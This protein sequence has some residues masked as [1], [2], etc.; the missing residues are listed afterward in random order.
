MTAPNALPN[1][2]ENVRGLSRHRWRLGLS[3]S[4]RDLEHEFQPHTLAIQNTPPSPFTR[5]VLWCLTLLLIIL[6]GWSWF[7]VIPITTSAPAKFETD[8]RTKVVQSL[9]TGTVTNILVQ[10][11][12]RVSKGQSLVELDPVADQA[13]MQSQGK[14]LTLNQSQRT[15]LL[16]EI[17]GYHQA[18]GFKGAS[19]SV[20]TLESRVM[21]ADM[22]RLHD[23]LATDRHK[24][25]AAEASLA[26]GKATLAEYRQRTQLDQQQVKAAAPLVPEGA[27]SGDAFDQLKRQAIEDQG[28]LNAQVKQVS[29]LRE[30][31]KTARTQLATDK[32]QFVDSQY[33]SLETN[34]SKNYQLGSKYITA[35]HQ[36]QMDWLRSP[37][38]GTIQD[39][40]VASLGT[41]VQS[42]ETLAT[43]VPAKGPMVVEADL[44]AKQAGF[45][46][47]GQTV[48]IK[49]TA[50][51]FEQYG[52]IPGRVTWVSPTAETDSSI[53]Q[54]PTGEERQPDTPAKS[55]LVSSGG[56]SES[57]PPPTLFY[58]V[59]IKPSRN[60]LA[61]DGVRHALSPGMTATVDVHT[62]ERR[63]IEFFLDPI[64]KYLNN[65]M[66]VR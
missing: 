51:P 57:S 23:Q 42:G 27:M 36:Y 47:V 11:G 48:N 13:N 45:V 44:P 61:A 22:V 43:I 1:N 52:S 14:S 4:G 7:S 59:H 9:N 25:Q 34:Q 65:G 20:K 41:V 17:Q 35:K 58:Q 66:E 49:V 21:R 30:A 31:V 54:T 56:D 62:G 10:D 15:R 39:L 64:V 55:G 37:V 6:L 38:N 3:Q 19:P 18:P 28:E 46:K 60:W 53:N 29:Q 16:A 50:Y 32:A 40:N 2:V 5:I 8:A 26:A 12:Q 24:T 33:Q 63:V